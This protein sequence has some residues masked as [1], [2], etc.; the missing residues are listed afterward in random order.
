MQ[1][2]RS[3]HACCFAVEVFDDAQFD[4]SAFVASTR[5][6]VPLER[7]RD[8]LHEHLADRKQELYDLINRDYADFILVS[9]KLSG[10]GSKV[11]H[12]REPMARLLARASG[13]RVSAEAEASRLEAKLEERR[14]VRERKNSVQ[15]FLRFMSTLDTA[16][17]VLGIG[18]R[19]ADRLEDDLDA[20]G[21]GGEGGTGGGPGGRGGGSRGRACWDVDEEDEGFDDPD[22]LAAFPGG[23][24]LTTSDTD[25]LSAAG[26][27]GTASGS[28]VDGDKTRE[29]EEELKAAASRAQEECALLERAAHYALMM[30]ADLQAAAEDEANGAGDADATSL[31]RGMSSRASRVEAEITRRLRSEFA[32][33]LKPRHPTAAAGNDIGDSAGN[34]AGGGPAR[35]GSGGGGGARESRRQALL[36]CLRPFSALGSGIEAEKQFARAVMQPFLEA[37]FTP[38]IVDG[39]ERGSSKGL[40]PL[41]NELLAYVKEVAGDAVEAAEDMFASP[42][43]LDLECSPL[44]ETEEKQEEA[45]AKAVK[46]VDVMAPLPVDLVCNGVWRPVQQVLMTRLS[47]IFATGMVAAQHSNFVLCME[48]LEGLAAIAGGEKRPRIRQRLLGQPSVAEFKARWNLPI[49]FQLRSREISSR[50]EASLKAAARSRS[51]SSHSAGSA[52]VGG[53]GAVQPPAAAAAEAG[54]QEEHEEAL[55]AF[56]GPAFEL[57]VFREA[58][59]CLNLCWSDEVF[60]PSLSHR[61]LRLSLQGIGRVGAWAGSKEVLSL[62]PDDIVPVAADLSK[63]LGAL[64]SDFVGVAAARISAPAAGERNREGQGALSEQDAKELVREVVMEAVGAWGGLVDSL[65]EKATSQVAAQCNTILQAV[66]GITATYRMT[67]KPPPQRPSPFVPNVL[68]ALREFDS[69]WGASASGNERAG[70]GGAG[71]KDRVVVSVCSRYL[72]IVSELLLTVRQMENTLNKRRVTARRGSRA[73]AG[74]QGPSDKD[75]IMMQ[76]RLDVREFGKEAARLGVDVSSFPPYERLL[77]VVE[78]KDAEA[79]AVEG[80]AS[81]R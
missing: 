52:G 43:G 8:D 28:G 72:E 13:L 1:E 36:S 7:L 19:G 67:N 76:L 55:L 79:S 3:K 81:S 40:G 24:A 41:L 69:R 62:H 31:L 35:G 22:L 6:L 20:A 74:D 71:W 34:G 11:S 9:T 78:A 42:A 60:L 23:L 12:L 66:K 17:G 54:M 4:P 33:L 39:S 16:E 44:G 29:E 26:V 46:E 38:G 25:V 57:G 73:G 30:N 53:D 2:G 32:S 47:S 27:S 49:Y 10:V 61:F 21:G 58:W 5:S 48:F 77:E 59:R 64:Q 18:D 50:L 51:G 14:V 63:L 75:K 68:R 70:G 80:P 45:K 15:R 65:W 56:D 37:R